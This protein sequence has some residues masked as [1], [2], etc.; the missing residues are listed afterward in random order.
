MSQLGPTQVGTVQPQQE[1]LLGKV[2]VVQTQRSEELYCHHGL[3]TE[4]LVKQ[5]EG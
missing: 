1:R 2:V 4:Y 5:V 3:A